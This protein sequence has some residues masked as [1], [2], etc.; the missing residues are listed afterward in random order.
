MIRKSLACSALLLAAALA[1]CG[2]SADPREAHAFRAPEKVDACTLFPPEEAQAIA[3]SGVSLL[4]SA[5][6]DAQGRAPHQCSY[7][8]GSAEA[9][10]ILSL[11]VR[12]A[13]TVAEAERR[14]AASR[15]FLQTLSKGQ[16]QD[17]SGVGDAAFWAGGTVGQL[18]TRKGAVWL[19]VTIQ[20]GK[21]PLG[22]ARRVAEQAFARMRPA[23][24]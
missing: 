24:R 23:K 22:A 15:P 19:V 13:K 7:N 16:V 6:E 8:A 18:H 5:Y 3:G 17:V 9:P 20:A 4:S 10:Q 21:D 12:P 2:P 14:Q 1:A 11:E